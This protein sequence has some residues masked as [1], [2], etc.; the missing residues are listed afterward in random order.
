MRALASGLLTVALR[1]G[2]VVLAKLYHGE[3]SA[4]MYANRTQAERMAAKV[5]GTVHK[6]FGRPFYVRPLGA[7]PNPGERRDPTPNGV[8]LPRNNVIPLRPGAAR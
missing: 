6:G 1:S 2:V 4:L 3:P 5:G 7:E 8:C